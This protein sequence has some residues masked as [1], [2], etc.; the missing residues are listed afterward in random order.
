MTTPAD[1]FK[2]KAHDRRPSIQATLGFFGSSAVPA[3][4]GATVNFILRAKGGDGKPA[5]GAAAVV[6]SPAQIIDA[7]LAVVRYD[8]KVGDTATP[9]AYLAEWEV[10]WP[11]GEAVITQTFPTDAYNDVLIYA[12]LDG[13]P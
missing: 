7:D 10:V 3:L 13:A 8:W 1:P 4:T 6:N 2:I 5:A 9:G 12:D 11:D